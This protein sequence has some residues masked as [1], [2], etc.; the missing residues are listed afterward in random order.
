MKKQIILALFLAALALAYAKPSLAFFHRASI[1]TVPKG[2]IL[3][4]DGASFI[5]RIDGTSKI[6]RAGGC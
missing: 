6:C 5:L 4:I 2:K 1:G 3:R